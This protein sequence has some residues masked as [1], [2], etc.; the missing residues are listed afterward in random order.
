MLHNMNSMKCSSSVLIF[1]PNTYIH[2]ICECTVNCVLWVIGPRIFFFM[3]TEA[4][5]RI[6]SLWLF[7]FIVKYADWCFRGGNRSINTVSNYA[8]TFTWLYRYNGFFKYFLKKMVLIQLMFMIWFG[9]SGSWPATSFMHILRARNK[10]TDLME[11][12]VTHDIL[13]VF[14]KMRSGVLWLLQKFP[15]VLLFCCQGNQLWLYTPKG[16]KL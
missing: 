7:A 5:G 1:T 8:K 14:S 10:G 3:W 13:Y 2:S 11:T 9:D 6:L 15:S 12:F 4:S 16:Q